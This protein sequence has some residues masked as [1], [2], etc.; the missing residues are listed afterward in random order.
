MDDALLIARLGA[1]VGAANVK[2]DETAR[3]E[4]SQSWYP[5]ET[6][7]K[8]S[9]G[10]SG[11]GVLPL[12]LHR[13]VVFPA[14]AGEVAAVVRWANETRTPLVPVG[15][16]SNTVGGTQP[17]K[18]SGSV[19]V[20]L[21]RLQNLTWDE[22]SLL[23]R[24]GA[25]WNLHSLE[26]TLNRHGYTLGQVPQSLYLATVGGSV[27][28]NA[29]GLLSGK[30]GRQADRTAALEVVL[31]TGVI[32]QTQ[33]APGGSAGPDIARLIHGS[34]GTL[35]IVTEAT[36]HMRPLPEARA[37]GVFTFPDF[38]TG[39]DALRLIHR[40]DARPAAV[41][42]FDPA[43]AEEHLGQGGLP[44]QSALLLFAFEGDELS[45]TGPYQVA[46][47]VCQKVGGSEQ[48]PDIGE[49][50]WEERFET[51]WMAP[52]GR[53][54]GIA[55]VFA[56]SAP[57]SRLGGVYAAMG[58]A[59]APLVTQRHAHIGHAYASGAAL[60]IIFEAQAE[61]G[62]PEAA[63]ELYGRITHAAV[64]ACQ[65]AGGLI[66]HH[67]GIGSAYRDAMAREWGEAGLATLRQI[68]AALDPNNILNPGKLFG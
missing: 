52:N 3:R 10:N 39:L 47:A 17:E 44:T 37:W 8:Q 7:Q 2:T 67:Y 5:R 49:A 32:L 14:D 51:G 41:R 45:Q 18:N 43:G 56:V 63:L 9:S 26:E 1:I 42:L 29:V 21:S 53:P 36:L 57:W 30:Y 35:G 25:G 64:D 20:S 68:K 4:A 24:A 55:D 13:A 46:H 16:S 12:R 6:K 31:A 58:T 54:G 23:C 34:E 40:T 22:E 62:T 28:A 50:W 27:A 15:G 48:S 61:P 33:A 65:D 66:A 38:V 11:G 60:N 19:A 59:L